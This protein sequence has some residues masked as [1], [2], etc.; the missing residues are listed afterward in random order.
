[1]WQPWRRRES[2]KQLID[3]QRAL[4]AE[5]RELLEQEKASTCSE[6][7]VLTGAGE[8]VDSGSNDTDWLTHLGIKP[9]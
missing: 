3:E 6:I 1:M 2:L 9:L 5:L 8:N 4:I 7:L